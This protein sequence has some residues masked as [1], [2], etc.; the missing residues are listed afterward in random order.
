[1]TTVRST[2]TTWFRRNII[3]PDPHPQLSRLDVADGRRDGWLGH[4]HG[5]AA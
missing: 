4:E 5:S 2:L 3:A 1:M